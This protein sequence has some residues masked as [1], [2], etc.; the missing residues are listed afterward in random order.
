M[1]PMS[2]VV[3]DLTVTSLLD[4]ANM[5]EHVQWLRDTLDPLI[6]REGPE[7]ISVE[8]ALY[9]DQFFR[10]LLLTSLSVQDIRSTRIHLALLEIAGKSTRWPRGLIERTETVIKA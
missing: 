8:D 10:K 3:K 5:K 9:L 7:A 1:P 4:T 2:L 6:A